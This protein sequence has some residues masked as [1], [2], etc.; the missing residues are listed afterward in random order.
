M[1]YLRLRPRTQAGFKVAISVVPSVASRG[2]VPLEIRVH[3][4]PLFIV[5]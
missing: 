5:D 3:R 4:T 2:A 1:S